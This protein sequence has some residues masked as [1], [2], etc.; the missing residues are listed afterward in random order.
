MS[1]PQKLHLERRNEIRRR[2]E[3]WLAV[4]KQQYDAFLHG[5]ARAIRDKYGISISPQQLGGIIR[6][7]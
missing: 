3:E 1:I 6:G 7:D 4:D 2:L 5:V